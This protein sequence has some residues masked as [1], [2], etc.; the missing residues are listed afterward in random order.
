[1]QGLNQPELNSLLQ[2]NAQNLIPQS[3]QTVLLISFVALNVATLIFIIAYIFGIIRKRKVQTA[4]LKMHEDVVDIKQLLK[5][6]ADT[7]LSPTTKD[8]SSAPP[9]ND[10]VNE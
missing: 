1:M 4:I 6:L 9:V 2:G 8:T 5:T 7:K 10:D 3:M